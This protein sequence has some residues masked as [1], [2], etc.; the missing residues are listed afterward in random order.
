LFQGQRKPKGRIQPGRGWELGIAE[1]P[2]GVFI[3]SFPERLSGYRQPTAILP[4]CTFDV[5]ILSQKGFQKYQS[6]GSVG[7]YMGK[8]NGYPVSPAPHPERKNP[9]PSQGKPHAGVSGITLQ[10]NRVLR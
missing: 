8:F 6:A 4:G 5:D 9:S 10:N 3:L 1:P 2:E 7:K